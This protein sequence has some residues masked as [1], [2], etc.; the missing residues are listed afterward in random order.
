MSLQLFHFFN[1]FAAPHHEL[2]IRCDFWFIDI[3][4][5]QYN[6]K[7]AEIVVFWEFFCVDSIPDKIFDGGRVCNLPDKH[8]NF[9]ILNNEDVIVDPI[10]LVKMFELILVNDKKLLI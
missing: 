4:I 10:I 5:P 6:S 9:L 7:F 1:S 2:I 3:K 8:A